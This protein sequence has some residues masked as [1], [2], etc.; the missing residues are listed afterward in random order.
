MVFLPNFPYKV[1]RV[2][3]KRKLVFCP[4]FFYTSV[5]GFMF[6]IDFTFWRVTFHE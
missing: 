3:P 5:S 2:F 4:I 6:G 1:A